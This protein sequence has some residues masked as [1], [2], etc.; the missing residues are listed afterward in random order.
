MLAINPVI[1][2]G[3]SSQ[4]SGRNE[5]PINSEGLREGRGQ[6]RQNIAFGIAQFVLQPV[7]DPQKLVTGFGQF[8]VGQ[9]QFLVGGLDL[10]NKA[11][12]ALAQQRHVV[13][14]LLHFSCNVVFRGHVEQHHPGHIFLGKKMNVRHASAGHSHGLQKKRRFL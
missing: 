12:L 8:V 10:G 11:R 13:R 5:E 7:V 9:R 4:F 3:I 2:K 6:D 1:T 14:L